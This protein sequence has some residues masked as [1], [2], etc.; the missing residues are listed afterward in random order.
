MAINRFIHSISTT[1]ML[2]YELYDHYE[3]Y[4]YSLQPTF[5]MHLPSKQRVGT[6]NVVVIYGYYY[7][8]PL[9][10]SGREAIFLTY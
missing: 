5:Y 3:S 4:N 9:F 10:A 7:R 1:N 8:L 6:N 2:A